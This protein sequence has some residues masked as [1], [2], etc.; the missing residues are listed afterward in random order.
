MKKPKVSLEKRTELKKLFQAQGISQGQLAVLTGAFR[1][2]LGAWLNG[3]GSISK[4]AQ[5]QLVELAKSLE[6]QEGDDDKH[7]N[8]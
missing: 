5:Q 4:Q 8:E 7:A 6:A 2:N 3:S 1:Q